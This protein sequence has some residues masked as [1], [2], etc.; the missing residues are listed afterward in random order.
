MAIAVPRIRGHANGL[1]V[2]VVLKPS[3]SRDFKFI[4]CERNCFQTWK[5]VEYG[6]IDVGD[7]TLSAS[8]CL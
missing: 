7:V 2:G 8:E 1:N 5:V 3:A 4:R 6:W